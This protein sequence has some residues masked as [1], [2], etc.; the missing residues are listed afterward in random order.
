MVSLFV[1]A[2]VLC[3]AAVYYVVRAVDTSG[4]ASTPSAET[5]VTAS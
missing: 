5:V 3:G 1:D 4:N 2:T